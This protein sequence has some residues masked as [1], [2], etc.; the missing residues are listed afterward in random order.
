[1]QSHLRDDWSEEILLALRI[2]LFKLSIWDH[3]ASYGAALQNLKYTDARKKTAHQSP[4]STWQK[5]LYGMF[6]VG[7][8]YGWN[9]WESWLVDQE[10]GY[11]EVCTSLKV[12]F[13]H[14]LTLPALGE[15]TGTLAFHVLHID[16]SLDCRIFIFPGLPRQRSISHSCGSHSPAPPGVSH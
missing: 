3:D 9:K 6:T 1:M 10:G 12:L 14:L 16:H 2:V 15:C 7:G 11:N 4:P 8:R 5:V 13:C